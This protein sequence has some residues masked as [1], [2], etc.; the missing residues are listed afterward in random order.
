FGPA[1]SQPLLDRIAHIDG[2]NQVGL[3][4]TELGKSDP[5]LGGASGA[6]S[7]PEARAATQRPADVAM[8]ALSAAAGGTMVMPPEREGAA[9][10]PVGAGCHADANVNGGSASGAAREGCWPGGRRPRPAEDGGPDSRGGVDTGK[11]RD[12]LV[13]CMLAPARAPEPRGNAEQ[14]GP[15]A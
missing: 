3:A 5:P 10:V 12:A 13:G 9:A 14:R 6:R 4:A 2:T 1:T 15:R 11:I 7:A 8:G